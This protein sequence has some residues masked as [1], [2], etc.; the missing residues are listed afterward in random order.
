MVLVRRQIRG[1][2][3]GH[4]APAITSFGSKFYSAIPASVRLYILC[5]T[6]ERYNEAK[7]LYSKYSWAYPILMK[8][9]DASF[10]NAFWKQLLEIHEDWKDFDMVGTLSFRAY[11]KISMETVDTIINTRG[12]GLSEFYHFYDT[13][14]P[15]NTRVHP[16][17]HPITMD[18][19]RHF[20][21]RVPTGN[22]CNYWMCTPTLMVRFIEW[23]E[24][25]MRPYIFAHP[26]AM[27]DSRYG[28]SVS[29][30]ELLSRIGVPYYPH[31]PFVLERTNKCFFDKVILEMPKVLLITHE[32]S[33]TG[34][35]IALL[36]LG[37]FL[38]TVGRF[39]VDVITAHDFKEEL[40]NTPKL[41][42]IIGNTLVS[43]SA[44]KKIKQRPECKVFWWIHEW[45]EQESLKSY[46]WLLNDKHIYNTVDQLLFPCN[47][48]LENFRTYVPWLAR[49][50][51][52]VLTY[53]FTIPNIVP[54]VHNDSDNTIVMTIVGTIDA[55][56]NQG[57]FIEHVFAPLCAIY[58]NL[59][60]L[61]IG[62]QCS[63]ISV[64]DVLTDKVQFIGEV[65]DVLP[66]I[67]RADIHISYSRNEVLP[68]NII[69][70]MSLGKAILAT[71]VGGCSDLITD[72]MT[73]YLVSSD[74][75]EGA[76]TKLSRLIEDRE[77][78]EQLGRGALERFLSSYINTSVFTPIL[79]TLTTA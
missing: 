36:K 27:T 54:A 37:H 31:I 73:G 4:I 64:P 6:I 34:A 78:R 10:E 52:N 66:H 67:A 5:H 33:L 32:S 56:K 35:P 21:F 72:G 49:E 75:H 3:V 11:Q 24:S 19:L 15:L 51:C 29:K 44:M 25:Q 65:S 42:A 18:I 28:G 58:P 76:I 60:L 12:W 77:L 57:A 17:L 40:L 30:D 61:L 20:N 69:E 70:A 45:P 53:G 43:Y 9:N 71:D 46:P 23:F 68:L 59:R 7:I 38:S 1:R 50:K 63:P 74:L 2:L 62:K 13:G 26:L 8:Y 22:Y 55:R 14:K 39:H 41:V 47:K 16:N 79:Q 48:A